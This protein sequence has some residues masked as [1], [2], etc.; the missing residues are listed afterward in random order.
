MLSYGLMGGITWASDDHFNGG[1]HHWPLVPATG[2]LSFVIAAQTAPT[3][4]AW[5]V[6]ESCLLQ[7]YV[8]SDMSLGTLVDRLPLSS[9][10]Y[11]KS[12]GRT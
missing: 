10:K 8:Q 6:F 9:K 1:I 5:Y 11:A 12:Q 3:T 7:L 4:K 2:S